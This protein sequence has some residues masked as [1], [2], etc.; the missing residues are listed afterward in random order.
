MKREHLAFLVEL[1]RDRTGQALPLDR[2]Y[3]VESR[4]AP[5]ARREGFVSVTALI[6]TLRGM[7]EPRL[8][9]AAA[10]ALVDPETSFF[11]DREPFDR[12]REMLLPALARVRPGRPLR[13][14]S[15]GC[16]AGQEA[17]SMAIAGLQAEAANPSLQVEIVATDFAEA[18]VERARSGLY[19][20][21]EVQR[22]LPIRDLLAH[23]EPADDLWRAKPEVIS[24][25]RFGRVNLARA[26]PNVG[27]FDVVFCRYVLKDFTTEARVAALQQ[28]AGVITPG[29]VLVMGE[30]ES[31]LD[32]ALA[33]G[34]AA[35]R[36][37]AGARGLF[38][39]DPA[40]AAA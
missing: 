12:L 30:G 7:A 28:L 38:Q 20:H 27:R 11:R 13:V 15:A 3:V 33:Q 19:T 29:G 23:F 10:E 26:L 35:F 24:R 39:R 37:P 21:F 8:A 5:L 22:G 14:W 6:E 2:L 4:L 40:A 25:I 18:A 34:G 9:Q 32:I 36:Q 1:L 17:V 31:P 16:G